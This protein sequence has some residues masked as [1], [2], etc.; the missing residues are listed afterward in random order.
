MQLKRLSV[1]EALSL[2]LNRSYNER[3][4]AKY[5]PDRSDGAKQMKVFGCRHCQYTSLEETITPPQSRNGDAPRQR[6]FTFNGLISHAKEKWGPEFLFFREREQVSYYP[7]HKILRLGDEDFF[8]DVRAPT[9]E[10][11]AEPEVI[12]ID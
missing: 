11:Q 7:R 1:D 12:V 5:S 4:L 10:V 9:D 6:R 8:R 2:G 3:S